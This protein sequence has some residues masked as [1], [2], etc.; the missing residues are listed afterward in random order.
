MNT[1]LLQNSIVRVIAT[2]LACFFLPVLAIAQSW[3]NIDPAGTTTYVDVTTS[4]DGKLAVIKN[5]P[6][7]VYHTTDDGDTWTPSAANALDGVTAFGSLDTIGTEVFALGTFSSDLSTW[8]YRSSDLVNWTAITGPDASP[9]FLNPFVAYKATGGIYVGDD[10]GSI[11]FSGDDAA[12]FVKRTSG[13]SGDANSFVEFDGAVYAATSSGIYSTTNDGQNWSSSLT[14]VGPFSDIVVFNGVLYGS[15][16][17]VTFGG[18]YRFTNGTGWERVVSGVGTETIYAAYDLQ[19]HAGVLYAYGRSSGGDYVL[20][21]SEDGLTWNEINQPNQPDAYWRL[22]SSGGYLILIGGPSFFTPNNTVMRLLTSVTGPPQITL[23]PADTTVDP[24]DPVTLVVDAGGTEPLSYQ[25]YEGASG[26]TSDP[27]SGATMDTLTINE[28]ADGS[29]YWVRVTNG[30][31]SVDSVTA[32]ITV[33]GFFT[34]K[35][36]DDGIGDPGNRSLTD[37]VEDSNGDL[38]VLELF[39]KDFYR[40]QDEGVTWSLFYDA[41]SD[42]PNA[43]YLH[44][45]NGEFIVSGYNGGAAPVFYHSSDAMNWTPSGS[46]SSQ[47]Q[48]VELII[49]GSNIYVADSREGFLR[50]TDSG[51]TFSYE[52][53]GLVLDQA[54]G[55]VRSG[56]NLVL[57]VTNRQVQISGDG[58]LNWT[59]PDFPATNGLGQAHLGFIGTDLYAAGD[60]YASGLWRSTD[61]G[62][63]WTKTITPSGGVGYRDIQQIGSTL[64]LMTT[65]TTYVLFSTTDGENANPVTTE[66]LGGT[67]GDSHFALAGGYLWMVLENELYRLKLDL[68]SADPPQITMQPEDQT[69]LSGQTA[70]FTIEVSGTEPFTYQWYQGNYP[71]TGTAVGTNSPSFTTDPLSETMTYWCHVSNGFGTPAHSV[72]VQAI[73]AQPPQIICDLRDFH[74]W[75]DY[76]TPLALTYFSTTPVTFE[77]YYGDSGDTGEPIPGAGSD[78][79]TTAIIEPDRNIWARLTNAGGSV[80][81]AAGA[82]KLAGWA[83]GKMDI[84]SRIDDDIWGDLAFGHHL[85]AGGRYALL[86]RGTNDA[87]RRDLATGTMELANFSA[88]GGT[89]IS[90]DGRYVVFTSSDDS[91]VDEVA[92][93]TGQAFLRDLQTGE[94][95]WVSPTSTGGEPNND[96]Q[97]PIVSAD[98]RYVVFSTYASNVVPNDDNGLRDLFVHDRVTG[99]TVGLTRFADGSGNGSG[100][101]PGAGESIPLSDYRISSDGTTVIF[102][103]YEELLDGEPIGLYLYDL[104]TGTMSAPAELRD[105]PYLEPAISATG[106]YIAFLYNNS[107]SPL[108]DGDPAGPAQIPQGAYYVLDRE[109]G[110]LSLLKQPQ[111]LPF[112]LWIS[113]DGCTILYTSTNAGNTNSMA[114]IG[115][116]TPGLDDWGYRPIFTLPTSGLSAAASWASAAQMS[117]DASTVLFRA[118]IWSELTPQYATGS[119]DDYNTTNVIALTGLRPKGE[120]SATY[121][122]FVATRLK[123]ADPEDTGE[124]DDPDNDGIPNLL[125]FVLGLDPLTPSAAAG[126]EIYCENDQAYVRYRVLKTVADQVRIETATILGSGANWTEQTFVD[127]PTT[128]LGDMVEINAQLDPG[129]PLPDEWFVRLV[130]EDLAFE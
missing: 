118:Q 5:S 29:T 89:D 72:D 7:T 117:D 4:H 16:N 112:E 54:T 2:A 79:I 45:Q 130:Y 11:Y 82:G 35:K 61:N 59:K 14:G 111:V 97:R 34:W 115:V 77:W 26:N 90:P 31:G 55:I 13:S 66:G 125:E 60:S 51:A 37:P 128:D 15:N 114:Y 69:I 119:N 43:S 62:A 47:N 25:W 40:S 53:T 102:T 91:L 36:L 49:E 87:Y 109:T 52:T 76:E 42:L 28:P 50:S 19:V 104:A 126:P 58:G 106:R 70:T 21:G 74:Y 99:D 101:G 73:V 107:L 124:Y 75:L 105:G 83:P 95:F 33:R 18:V 38:Y 23:E 94:T 68:Q 80:D 64:Y 20:W 98:G 22:G 48:A 108:Q 39:T 57:A 116:R 9:N 88:G 93:T 86:D 81:S 63:S 6:H 1:T 100:V 10:Y 46:S 78:L 113:E 122:D 103:I 110:D 24:E 30:E 27:I 92:P 65:D 123:L 96:V 44:Y 84:A 41:S 17:N 67:P 71:A 12:T 85:S 127:P 129:G 3:E 120:T 56:S 121:Q 32:T 8:M